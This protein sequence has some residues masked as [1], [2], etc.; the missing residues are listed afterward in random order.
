[1]ILP[2]FQLTLLEVYCRRALT[3]HKPLYDII[4]HTRIHNIPHYICIFIYGR[5]IAHVACTCTITRLAK[6][7]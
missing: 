5:D 3:L 2:P 1:M 7:W 6:G 4:S